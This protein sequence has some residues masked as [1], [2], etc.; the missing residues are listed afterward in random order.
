MASI[1][2]AG[3]PWKVESVTWSERAVWKSSW[4]RSPSSSGTSRRRASTS[5]RASFIAATQART[6]GERTP[7][8]S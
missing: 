4:R 1:S 6:A 8:R 5:A 7:A 3:Q 2:W